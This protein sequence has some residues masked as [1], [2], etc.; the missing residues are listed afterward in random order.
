MPGPLSGVGGSPD[1]VYN[2]YAGVDISAEIIL[3]GESP[4]NLGELQTISYSTHRENSPIR[5]L[6]H[7]NA[8]GFVKGPRT[9]AGSMIFTVFDTYTFYRLRSFRDAIGTSI[10]PLADMLPPFDVVITFTNEYG[11]FSKMRIYGITIVDEGQT[12]SVDDLV[13]EQTYT[14]MARGIQPIM[15]YYPDSSAVTLSAAG[16]GINNNPNVLRFN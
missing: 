5:L 10:W 7:V 9:I 13:T 15:A 16:L 12:M 6:G 1:V 4:L 11:R 3:P 14:Y 8:A 2:S